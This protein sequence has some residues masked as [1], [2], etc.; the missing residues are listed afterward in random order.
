MSNWLSTVPNAVEPG[1]V[2][3]DRGP[4]RRPYAYMVGGMLALYLTFAGGLYLWRGTYFAPDLPDTWALVLLIGALLLGRWKAFVRDWV[5]FV[6]L[7]FGYEL[8][9]GFAGTVV[10]GDALTQTTHVPAG[11]QITWLIDADKALFRG[12]V[13]TQWL[14]EKLYVPGTVHWYDTLALA[15]YSLHFAL[16]LVF[17]FVLWVG[18]RERF[19]QFSVTLLFMSYTTFAI[20]LLVPTGPPWLAAQW[21]LVSGVRDPFDQAIRAMLPHQFRQFDTLTIWTKASPNPV[22]AFP[23]LHAA[24]P[25]LVLLFSVKYFGRKGWL[26]L[27]YNALVWFS[28]VYLAQHWVVDIPAGM[29]WAT[30]SFFVVQWAWPRTMVALRDRRP[31]LKRPAVR[32]DEPVA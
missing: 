16:P 8:L 2:E 31:A 26:F 27:I 28:V 22:A 7:V 15:M 24:F 20:F 21:G 19:W 17:G 25:W 30:G 4:D 29:A 11:V 6:A 10:G 12:H 18:N 23:S 13:P 3:Q 9:R 5:P 1:G 32:L 14:Q